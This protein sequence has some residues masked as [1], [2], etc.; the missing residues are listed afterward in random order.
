[1]YVKVDEDVFVSSG[2]AERLFAAYEKYRD[3]DNLSLVCDPDTNTCQLTCTGNAQCPG[4]F[5]CFD[6]SGDG[7]SYC[8]NPTCTL[9]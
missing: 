4:S 1:M 7:A 3:R 6:A 9:N 5:S 2:W 8:V